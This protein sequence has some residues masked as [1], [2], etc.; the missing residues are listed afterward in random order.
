[1]DKNINGSLLILGNGFDLN[2]GL[3]SSFKHF[4]STVNPFNN[5][6][7][8]IFHHG[9]SSS[10]KQYSDPMF[11][12]VKRD[13]VLWM[14][15]ED[16][17]KRILYMHRDSKEEKYRLIRIFGVDN[18]CSLLSLC[19]EQRF[20]DIYM[21]ANVQFSDFKRFFSKRFDRANKDFE[22]ISFLKQEL[23]SFEQDFKKYIDGISHKGEYLNKTK[24]LLGELIGT[25]EAYDILTFNYTTPD[26]DAVNFFAYGNI[27]HI[28]GSTDSNIII[29]FDSSDI[30]TLK[31]RKSQLSKAFQKLFFLTENKPLPDK[32]QIVQLK[33]YGHSLGDQDYSYF[34]SLFDYFD[35]YNNNNISL[36]FYYTPYFNIDVENEQYRND[37]VNKVYDLLNDYSLKASLGSEKSNVIISRLLLENRLFI[38]TVKKLS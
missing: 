8:L 11:P 30:H 36:V 14:D 1:M 25:E 24:T 32:E 35:I 27:N 10:D 4:F 38:K 31:D 12:V 18:Y 13:N 26:Y 9:F 22:I 34:H 17:I 15:I 7:Y 20:N 16:Y 23:F 37:Y 6:W 5:I 21:Y 28:H 29:G 3:N 2:C 33:F 19:Y